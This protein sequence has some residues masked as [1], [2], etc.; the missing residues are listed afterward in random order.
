M[1]SSWKSYPSCPDLAPGIQ[2]LVRG[3][4]VDGKASPGHDEEELMSSIG[5]GG[6]SVG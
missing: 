5:P 1:A 6:L 3:K 2:V 4:D